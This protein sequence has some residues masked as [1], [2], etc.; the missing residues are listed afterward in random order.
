MRLTAIHPWLAL[1]TIGLAL[2][3]GNAQAEKRYDP[4]AS[5]S[6]IRIGQTMPYSG[7]VSMLGTVGRAA[8]AYFDKLN[9]EGGINGR[10]VKLLSVDD[11]YN[12]AK[13]LEQTR[14]LVE[15]DEVLLIFNTVGTATNQ[16]THRY[17]NARRVPQLLILSGASKWND[18]KNN[19]W[20][21]SGMF[22]YEAEGRVYA[23]HLLASGKDPRIGVLSQND[24]FGR[25]F[26]RGLKT[27]LGS[28]AA[29]LIVAE[30][31]YEV[32]DP[33]VDS[34]MLTLKASGANVFMNFSNGKFT[35]QAL[36]RAGEL[37]WKPQTYL[38]MSASS[39][40]SILQPAGLDRAI[41]A[42]TIANQKNPLDP[43]W[44]DDAGMKEYFEFM[45]RW[46]PGLDITDS[47]NASGYSSARMLADVLRRCGDDLTH[48]N[49]MRQMLSLKD[50]TTPLM[51][52]GVSVTTGPDDYE[53]YGASRLQ[54]FDGKS[55][56]PFGDPV[57]SR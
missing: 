7:P 1:A 43:Q 30:T 4:G 5:D 38:P 39:I 20:T 6:E 48:D 31:T 3:A 10:K 8:S 19:P 42:V 55:W 24:D 12:P 9:A 17:L 11:G 21:L 52:P 13:T 16:A 33:T 40:A 18:P 32:T 45:K 14:R 44:K 23:R 56:I 50:Y 34:Q 22:A 49:V 47:F 57:S 51:L 27:G 29:N 53:L 15:N 26:L 54:R 46:A 35:A 28:R 2:L 36:R 41:G 25:D 37:G